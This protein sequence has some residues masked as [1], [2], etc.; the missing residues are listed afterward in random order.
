M[1]A[2]K[3]IWSGLSRGCDQVVVILGEGGNT[4]VAC[5][6]ADIVLFAAELAV[7]IAEGVVEHFIFCDSGVDSAEIEGTWERVGHIHTDLDEHN[8]AIVNQLT[9]HDTKISSQLAAH[10]AD[11]KARLGEIQGTVDEN[12]RLIK[13]FM[14]RQLEIMRLL[15]TPNGRRKVDAEVLTCTGDDC[16]EYPEFQ[17]CPNGSLKWNCR[18]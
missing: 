2:A 4:S 12:Q 17:L 15:I 5:I 13:I 11:I 16:P 9:A 6:A 8:T 14:S 10:D 3:V 7:G 1:E 18:P